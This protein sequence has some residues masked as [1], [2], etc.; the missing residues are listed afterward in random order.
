MKID[1][2]RVIPARHSLVGFTGEQVL[3]LGSI[4]LP[5]TTR[6]YPRQS[7]IMVRFLII[8]RPSAY[9]AILGRTALN[10]LKAVTSTPP[11]EHEIPHR[12]RSRCQKRRP[13]DG[14]RML[15]HKLEKAPRSCETRREEKRRRKIAITVGGAGR[16]VGKFR[17]R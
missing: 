15:Q 1:R 10:E 17:A 2:N 11:L 14:S 13:T 5:V 9:N 12:R 4:E 6:T 3:P 7:T 16:G 8:D